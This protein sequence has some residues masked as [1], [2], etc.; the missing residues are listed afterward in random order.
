MEIKVLNFEELVHEFRVWNYP[1][2]FYV[3]AQFETLL[4]DET[5][6]KQAVKTVQYY[7]DNPE[8]NRKM[9]D[10]AQE[11]L[12]R[13]YLTKAN[14]QA[15]ALQAGLEERNIMLKN[16]GTGSIEAQN[17]KLDIKDAQQIADLKAKWA[18]LIAKYGGL[19]ID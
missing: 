16:G 10:K 6:L 19:H 12:D 9:A 5:N 14:D 11:I 17:N 2:T 1:I 7:T 13:C 8:K 15:A 18:P 3:L 4:K